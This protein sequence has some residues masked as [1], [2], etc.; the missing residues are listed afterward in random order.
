MFFPG[1]RIRYY[2]EATDTGGGITTLPADTTGFYGTTEYNRL[3]TVRALPSLVENTGVWSQPEILMI[4]DFGHRGGENDFISAFAQNGMF[5]G[6]DYDTYTVRGPSSMV[7][8][9]I[10]SSGAHGASTVQIGGYDK[11]FY[12]SGNLSAGLLSDGS[13]A[14]GNDKGNDIDLLTAWYDLPGDRHAAFFGDNLVSWLGGGGLN[15]STFLS[16]ELGAVLLDND[17]S[18][19]ID[20]Q[21]APL[22][23]GAVVPFV[24]DIVAY[25]GCPAINQID[26]IQPI[27]GAIESHSFVASDGTTPYTSAASVYYERLEG[28]DR[29][30]AIT[31]PY[32]F[33]YVFNPITNRTNVNTSARTKLV[34]EILAAFGSGTNSANATGVTTPTKRLAVAQNIPNPFNPKTTITFF[35]PTDGEV[36]VR[37]FNLKGELVRELLKGR[38]ASG[39]N[40]VHWDGTDDRGARVSSGVYLYE[41]SGFGDRF[42]KKMALVK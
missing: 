40:S 27:A 12:V 20:G 3:F 33:A 22:V 16:N 5:E 38:V 1:D 6:E 32:G 35:A 37:V 14:G 19:E 34:E 24:T 23:R 15:G 21:T 11:L 10:G 36:T 4:N 26:S 28:I 41:V 7:S 29:R 18:D 17:V 8:N 39:D 13:N 31:F 42:T 25:G 9:G 2:L 30:V